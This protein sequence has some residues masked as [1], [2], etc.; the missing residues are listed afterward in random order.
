MA[1]ALCPQDGTRLGSHFF[2]QS[3]FARHCVA[4]ERTAVKVPA[5]LP[6]E[7]LGPLGC[8]VITGAGAMLFSLRLQVG[9]S[10]AILGTGGVGLSAVMA[11]RLIGRARDHCRRPDR[12]A[13]A[14]RA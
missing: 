7:M 13:A 9:Q 1:A 5:D 11:A 10:V 6:L 12:V 2:G 8:G 4:S 3:S 14:P